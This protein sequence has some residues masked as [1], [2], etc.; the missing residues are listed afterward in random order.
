MKYADKMVS[1]GNPN[2]SNKVIHCPCGSS[3]K[4]P[5]ERTSD[6]TKASYARHG[7]AYKSRLVYDQSCLRPI[8]IIPYYLIVYRSFTQ[9]VARRYSFLP[10]SRSSADTHMQAQAFDTPHISTKLTSNCHC[11]RSEKCLSSLR[12]SATRTSDHRYHII[13][14]QRQHRLPAGAVTDLIASPL[15]RPYNMQAAADHTTPR[16]HRLPAG[17]VTHRIASPR[18]CPLDIQTAAGLTTPK[19]PRRPAGAVV[20]RITFVNPA[21]AGEAR[22][23][24]VEGHPT[25]LLRRRAAGKI[26]LFTYTHI[27]PLSCIFRD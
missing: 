2:T 9:E 8:F 12:T 3:T 18:M 22:L 11:R 25:R 7:G 6:P 5:F 4:K 19:Q 20:D 10:H 1:N 27:I 24:G 15:M 13:T 23:G 17:A 16:Q 26:T 21:M 14:Y